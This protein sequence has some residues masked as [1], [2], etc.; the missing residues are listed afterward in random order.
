MTTL[1]FTLLIFMIIGAVIALETDDILS[2]IISLGV[3][4]FGLTIAFLFLAAPDIAITQIVV[5][6]LC[7]I[8]LIRAT[9]SRDLKD[10]T[11]REDLFGLGVTVVVLMVIFM[12]GAMALSGLPQFGH[13]VIDTMADAPSWTYIQDGL[14]KTGAANLVSAVLLDFR[15]YDTLGEATILFVAI[16]AAL[17]ILRRPSRRNAPDPN[18]GSAADNPDSAD[19]T[20]AMQ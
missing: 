1:L 2:A 5:E 20:G 17:A 3:L 14:D 18:P 12:L 8:L 13:P 11:G 9:I 19:P 4:G 7:L 6:V 10:T 15:A 16:I